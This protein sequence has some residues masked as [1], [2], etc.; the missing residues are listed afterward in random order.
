MPFGLRLGRRSQ[1][2]NVLSKEL[3]V[4]PVELLDQSTVE[5][6][7][8]ATSSGQECLENVCQRLGLQDIKYFGLLCYS[9]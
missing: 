3:F 5:C 7:L 8:L 2:Y 1:Q 6:T 4:V 9:R